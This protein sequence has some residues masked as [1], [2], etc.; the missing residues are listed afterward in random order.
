MYSDNQ[1]RELTGKLYVD[2]TRRGTPTPAQESESARLW[3]EMTERVQRIARKGFC[4][5]I[6]LA[7]VEDIE[8]RVILKLLSPRT[9][10]VA[11][12]S[13]SPGMYIAQMIRHELVDYVRRQVRETFL[14]HD[15]DENMAVVDPVSE[16]EASL[17][18]E[19][20]ERLEQSLAVLTPT[21]QRLLWKRFW[22]ETR[23]RDIARDMGLSYS[24]V[25]KRMFRAMAKLRARFIE[26]HS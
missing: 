8:Q 15:I 17:A 20:F 2:R 6:P 11:T 4:R 24:T 25:A 26:T 19:N 13:S 14:T 9:L 23:I 16:H 12:H 22:E 5:R 18:E 3:Q 10:R 7:D 21:E 1:W